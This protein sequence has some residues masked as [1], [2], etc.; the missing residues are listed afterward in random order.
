[1]EGSNSM[2]RS[3]AITAVQLS[4]VDVLDAQFAVEVAGLFGHCTTQNGV[5]IQRVGDEFEIETLD[6][7][8]P[9]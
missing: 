5:A 2:N 3:D 6:D 8:W 9:V 4:G 1:M 7:K